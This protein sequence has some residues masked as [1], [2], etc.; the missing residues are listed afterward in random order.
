MKIGFIGLGEMGY[1]IAA[2]LLKAGHDLKVWNRTKEKAQPLVALGAQWAETPAGAADAEVIFT[3]LSD[4]AAVSAATFGE[5]GI[6]TA[7]RKPLHVSMSTISVDLA[8][9]LAEAHGQAGGGYLSAP[10][11]GRPDAA[12]AAK[13]FIVTAGAPDAIERCAPLFDSIGQRLFVV[14]DRPMQANLVKL[15]GNFLIASAIEGMA[16]AMTLASKNGIERST[17]LDV[18]TGTLFDAPAYRTYGGILAEQRFRPAG[19]AAPL[20]LKD[21]RLTAQAA[22]TARVPMPM[23]GVVRD[24]LISTIAREG[25]D[26][27]W[28]GIAATVAANAGE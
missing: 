20:G 23:L 5:N 2:N 24:H 13:L 8:E 9:R 1:A 15:C 12:A 26:I 18:L 17:L 21:M 4:D 6:L 27:D 16:E 3:M 7:E 25:E 28:S 14:G 19:F 10:V 22:E 11:F